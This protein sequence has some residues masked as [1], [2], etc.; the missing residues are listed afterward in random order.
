V[1]FGVQKQTFTLNSLCT[2]LCVCV[3]V[4]VCVCVCACACTFTVCTQCVRFQKDGRGEVVAV[5]LGRLFGKRPLDRDYRARCGELPQLMEAL[6]GY[7]A[8]CKPSQPGLG[9]EWAF[10]LCCLGTSV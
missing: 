10:R 9:F 7:V 1:V 8:A 4:R 2:S 5:L 3:R 6:L